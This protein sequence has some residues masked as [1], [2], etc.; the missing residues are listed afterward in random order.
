ME[1]GDR[2]EGSFKLDVRCGT[3]R[4]VSRDGSVY[5]GDF[6]DNLPHGHGKLVKTEGDEYEGDVRSIYY[7]GLLF[8]QKN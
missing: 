8:A 7:C 2:Y 4:L 6:K 3:G 5:E 1:N